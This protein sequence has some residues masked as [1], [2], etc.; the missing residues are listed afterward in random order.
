MN[1][2]RQSSWRRREAPR[3]TVTYGASSAEVSADSDS[4]VM[5][6]GSDPD[7][8][9]TVVISWESELGVKAL[10]AKCTDGLN[11][12]KIEIWVSPVRGLSRRVLIADV[13]A[14]IDDVASYLFNAPNWSMRVLPQ[15]GRRCKIDYLGYG[16]PKSAEGMFRVAGPPKLAS[17][18]VVPDVARRLLEAV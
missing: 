2:R 17:S 7:G 5:S 10:I 14:G 3:P 11:D 4:V 8:V 18:T 1:K 9:P 12:E 6:R 16:L 13:M 15:R